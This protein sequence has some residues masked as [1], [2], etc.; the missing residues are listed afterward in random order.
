MKKNSFNS[1]NSS[2]SLRSKKRPSA[3]RVVYKKLIVLEWSSVP[4]GRAKGVKEVKDE[5][6]KN[7]Q[8]STVNCQLSTVTCPLGA[9]DA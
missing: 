4:L 2:D 7:C 3:E 1:Y 9:C 6:F 5:C 8:L